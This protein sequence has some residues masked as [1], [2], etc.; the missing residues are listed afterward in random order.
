LLGYRLY[1]DLKVSEVAALF[2]ADPVA[3]LAANSVDF[4]VPDV[5]N[6]IL[7]SGLF[8]RVPAAC[9]CSGGI[10]RSLSTRYTV[11]PADTLSSIAASVY[12]GLASPDQI[13]EAN[14]IQDP[15]A[16]DAG[17]TLVIP[18]PCTCFNSSD[19]F[20]PAVYLSYVVRQGDSV[21]AVAARYSTTVTDIMNCHFSLVIRHDF[22][23]SACAS[24]FP[25]YA[26]DYGLIVA[27][28][29]YAITASH[30]V[31][32]SCGPGNLK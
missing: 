7:P 19:N 20:L 24:M 9:S 4:S 1:A 27:N 28:G 16:L 25:K 29:T 31:Q 3:L 21:P 14:N 32:C 23:S 13:Q 22:P 6:R 5:E 30:C 26:S 17:R 11:R 15:S 10:R 18:L 12:G 8:L 2:Q